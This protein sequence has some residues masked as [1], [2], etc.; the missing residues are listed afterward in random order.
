MLEKM[1]WRKGEGLGKE[2]TGM[3]DPVRPAAD[4]AAPQS[5]STEARCGADVT[6][7][8]ADPA[9]DP[10]VPVGS[11]GRRRR[12]PGL[13]LGDQ[14][15]VPEELGESPREVR[16]LVPARRAVAQNAEEEIAQSLGQGG[17]A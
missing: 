11:G 17:G 8:S 14:V 10:E 5:V 15:Q 9:E 6:S 2:G 12:V 1:G 4:A 13:R 7:C 3:K 16:R